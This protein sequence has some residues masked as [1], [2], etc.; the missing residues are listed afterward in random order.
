MTPHEIFISFCQAI[1][2]F[3]REQKCYFITDSLDAI[4]EKINGA[5]NNCNTITTIDGYKSGMSDLLSFICCINGV[6]SSYGLDK[7]KQYALRIYGANCT[8][9]DRISVNELEE[10]RNELRKQHSKLGTEND[11]LCEKLHSLE[12]DLDHH[13]KLIAEKEKDTMSGTH[14]FPKYLEYLAR[15]KKQ[16]SD[17]NNNRDDRQYEYLLEKI[18]KLEQ[19]IDDQATIIERLRVDDKFVLNVLLKQLGAKQK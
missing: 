8:R 10:E 12:T 14:S 4:N 18:A 5:M 9:L 6:N 16:S 2:K 7:I 17:N 15:E 19:R 3:V 1:S 11:K 13:K